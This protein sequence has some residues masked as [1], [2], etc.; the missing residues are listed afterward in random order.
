MTN[1]V[2]LDGVSDG[3]TGEMLTTSSTG[4]DDSFR[5]VADMIENRTRDTDIW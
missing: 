1:R 2:S 3:D 4:G 5:R